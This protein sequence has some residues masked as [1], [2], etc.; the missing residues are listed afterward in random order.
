MLT[1]PLLPAPRCHSM[2]S[3]LIR[4]PNRFLS[5]SMPMWR[6]PVPYQIQCDCGQTVDVVEGQ[7][8]STV[9]C[10]CGRTV[11]IPS[12]LALRS[13]ARG[14]V[15]EAAAVAKPSR[16][17]AWARWWAIGLITGA[18]ASLIFSGVVSALIGPKLGRRGEEAFI[19]TGVT[20]YSLAY[21]AGMACLAIARGYRPWIG[22]ALWFLG[23]AFGCLGRGLA[24]VILP[25]LVGL[26]VLLLLPNRSP[27]PDDR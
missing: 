2:A 8:G 3:V 17:A 21:I 13:S 4:G 11:S 5:E 24:F 1:P 22:P 25:P 20:V 9:S 19:I 26:V 12:L 14:Q 18:W 23:N 27:P 15:K 6:T 7:A 16:N 10:S